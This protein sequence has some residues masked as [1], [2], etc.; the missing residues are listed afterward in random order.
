[1]NLRL[2]PRERSLLLLW[3][4]ATAVGWA[5]GFFVCETVKAFVSTLN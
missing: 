1:M 5:V 2:A 3:V 4:A